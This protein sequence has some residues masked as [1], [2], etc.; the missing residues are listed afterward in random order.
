[1]ADLGVEVLHSVHYIQRLIEQR[2]IELT[3]NLEKTVTYHDPCDLG[4]TFE[5]FD[6]PREI[7]KSVPGVDFVDMERSRLMA[8]CCGGGGNVMALDPELAADMAVVRLKDAV[9]V[10]AEIIVS[11]CSTCKDNLRKGVKAIHKD[12][13]PK[14]KVMDITEIVANAIE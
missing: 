11:G 5:I 3:I 13:R 10:D 6:E 1:L 7:L 9:E 2:R 4:R 14:I 12:E 8:R